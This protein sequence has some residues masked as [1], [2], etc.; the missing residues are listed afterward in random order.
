MFKY[1]TSPIAYTSTEYSHLKGEP[2]TASIYIALTDWEQQFEIRTNPKN[3]QLFDPKDDAVIAYGALQYGYDVPEYTEF[4]ID[5]EYR[6][7]SRVPRYIVIVASASKY[8]DFFTGGATSTLWLDEL[9]LDWD[10]D[11]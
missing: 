4:T 6:S 8:G 2:D 9:Q 1:F 11:Q 3:R 10:Y 5:L 7:T